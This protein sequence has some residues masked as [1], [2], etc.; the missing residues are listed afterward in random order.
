MNATTLL[1]N[2]VLRNSEFHKGADNHVEVSSICGL[3]N[4]TGIGEDSPPQG[5]TE[6]GIKLT[7]HYIINAIF[8]GYSILTTRCITPLLTRDQ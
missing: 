5:L 8:F 4:S 6:G 7:L 3:R 2:G 1:K